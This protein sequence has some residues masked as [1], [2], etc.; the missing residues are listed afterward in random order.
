MIGGAGQ[1][2]SS[3]DPALVGAPVSTVSTTRGTA[4]PVEISHGTTY[5]AEVTGEPREG[6][7]A[8]E[9]DTRSVPFGVASALAAHEFNP[10]NERRLRLVARP[11]R[12]RRWR[13]A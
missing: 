8:T 9:G 3:V 1:G 11:R 7:P 6:R 13:V 10:G 12:P 4:V 5:L 2:K